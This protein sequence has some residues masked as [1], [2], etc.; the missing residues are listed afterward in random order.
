M[1]SPTTLCQ[2]LASILKS[3]PSR[4]MARQLSSKSGIPLA[5]NASKQSL[6][7]TIREHTELLSPTISQTVSHSAAFKTGWLR[8]RS[9]R[10]TTFQGF[11][12]VISVILNPKGL[13]P[14]RKVK[15]LQITTVFV[16]LKHQL[17][18]A[19]MLSRLST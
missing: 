15:K 13:F 9:M 17:R 4:L 5:K 11:W 16:S 18:T 7:A 14:L 6:P 10:L 8:L 2:Q 19:K 12:S 3:K 1:F